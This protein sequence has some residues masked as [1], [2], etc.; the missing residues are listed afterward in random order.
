MVRTFNF[1]FALDKSKE[2]KEKIYY[3]MSQENDVEYDIKGWHMAFDQKRRVVT[4]TDNGT[5]EFLHVK[6]IPAEA[7]Y[8]FL[9]WSME[10][11]K[12]DF[13]FD[14]REHVKFLY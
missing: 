11:D 1:I 10:E 12:S 4:I 6:F 8:T 3:M 13:E 5:D 2:E 7:S 14:E 9:Q